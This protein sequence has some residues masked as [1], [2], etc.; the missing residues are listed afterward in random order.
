MRVLLRSSLPD[1]RAAPL[2]ALAAVPPGR[3]SEHPGALSGR[4]VLA[5]RAA[6]SECGG[7]H[8]ERR[9]PVSPGLAA[10][11]RDLVDAARVAGVVYGEQLLIA[12]ERAWATLPEVEEL[13]PGGTREAAWDRL[14]A[15]CVRAFYA[16]MPP[17]SE[18]PRVLRL[19]VN[20]SDRAIQP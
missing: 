16:P 20:Q 3:S 14:V 4:G 19:V 2:V 17:G 12:L 7:A 10:A 15:L 9:A 5:L 11:V 8:L 13:P 18:A 1:R 6:L